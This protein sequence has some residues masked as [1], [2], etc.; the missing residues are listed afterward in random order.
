M[1]G[2]V[3]AVSAGV[4]EGDA[5]QEAAAEAGAEMWK[6]RTHYD[7][8][9]PFTDVEARDLF[10]AMGTMIGDIHTAETAAIRELS[11]TLME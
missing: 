4:R 5:G 10:A 1:R 8:E 3:S 9:T 2:L 7:D 6:L 11:E